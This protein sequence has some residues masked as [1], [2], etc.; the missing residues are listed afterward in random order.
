MLCV[1]QIQCGHDNYILAIPLQVSH[2]LQ[3]KEYVGAKPA[4]CHPLKSI[5][6]QDVKNGIIDFSFQ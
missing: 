2:V 4:E 6:R 5:N 1:L 3:W